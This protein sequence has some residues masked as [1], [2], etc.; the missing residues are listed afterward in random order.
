MWSCARAPK[1]Q[2][3]S[4]SSVS[5]VV[6]TEEKAGV[7]DKRLAKHVMLAEGLREMLG[8]YPDHY[9]TRTSAD[10]LA[11][12]QFSSGTTGTPRPVLYNHIAATITAVNI[13]LCIG[14][15]S[16][17]S[18]F[19]P[20]SPAWGHG[21]MY[22]TIGPLIFG[23]AI[24]AY[25]GKYDPDTLLGA[26]EYWDVTNMSAIPLVY[27][28]MASKLDRYRLKLRRMTFT[29]GSVDIETIR[30]FQDRLGAFP[31]SFYGS[32]EV[33]VI[34]ND[35]DFLDY[36][37]KPG[38]MGQ[39]MLGVKV[40]VL[41]EHDNALPPGQTGQ[42]AVWRR[43]RWVRIGDYAMLDDDGYFWHKG[44]TD[45]VIKSAGY[46][47]GPFE[48]EAVL[49]KHPAVRRAAV[50]GSPDRERGMVVKAFIVP[51]TEPGDA[52][53]REIQD[54]VKTRLS[55]HEYPREIEFVDSLPETPDGK[56]RRSELR[57]RERVRKLAASP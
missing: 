8:R 39:P 38:S 37:A 21:I 34:V 20:S 47:I 25:S 52:L 2:P 50:V 26:L 28:T 3:E 36:V 49:E 48:I 46:T 41:D 13:K 18:F 32:T 43:D 22:G 24:G 12:I 53:I 10:T 6:T 33:G 42:M 55:R 29:G 15:R 40:A 16:D 35:Y 11:I 23:N 51:T 9:E 44:R 57:E 31:Q 54:F 1:I 27:R 4:G 7:V 5:A 45:D 30:A 19:C 14:L 56:I 17:D